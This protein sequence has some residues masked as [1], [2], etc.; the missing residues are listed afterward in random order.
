M[1]LELNLEKIATDAVEREDENHA[2][3]DFLKQQDNNEVD[4]LAHELNR[5][6]EPQISCVSCGNCCKSLMVSLDE[7]DAANLA[8][9]LG[10]SLEQFKEEYTEQGLSGNLVINSV[11]CRFLEGTACT[12]YEHRF[13][14]CRDFPSIH[15][16][17][18]NSR[19]FSMIMHYGRC[20]IVYNVWEGLKEKTGFKGEVK[21]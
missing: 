11:P 15:K 16:D 8:P 20:P 7:A 9:H 12:V 18:F 19:T 1:H 17:N 10:L 3:R 4:R 14:D 13:T 6:V 2:F 21:S 5:L